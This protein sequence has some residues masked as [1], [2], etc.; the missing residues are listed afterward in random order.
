ME[1][2]IVLVALIVCGTA[3]DVVRRLS[4]A[5]NHVTRLDQVAEK[6]ATVSARLDDLSVAVA[7]L[8]ADLVNAKKAKTYGPAVQALSDK[9]EQ[10]CA[11]WREVFATVESKQEEARKEMMTRVAG[12][13][14][15]VPKPGFNR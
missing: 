15:A 10:A 2:S 11:E 4:A 8:E 6:A 13:L 12:V 3:W 7:R 1:Y 9:L 14:Q 5:K